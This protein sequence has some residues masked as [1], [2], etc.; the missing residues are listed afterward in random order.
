LGG[1]RG[2]LQRCLGIEFDGD[3]LVHVVRCW[4]VPNDD[5]NYSQSINRILQLNVLFSSPGGNRANARDGPGNFTVM[6]P[7][8]A[9][10]TRNEGRRAAAWT[11]ETAVRC[12]RTAACMPPRD[13]QETRHVVYMAAGTWSVSMDS[14]GISDVLCWSRELP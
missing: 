2:T 4:G 14:I 7:R 13:H 10:S 3:L 9:L 12:T 5:R 6:P 1:W 8:S 11:S